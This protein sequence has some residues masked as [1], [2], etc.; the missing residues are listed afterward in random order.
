MWSEVWKTEHHRARAQWRRPVGPV[1]CTRKRGAWRAEVNGADETA[2]EHTAQPGKPAPLQDVKVVD[3]VGLSHEPAMPAK[4]SGQVSKAAEELD[5]CG[6]QSGSTSSWQTRWRSPAQDLV[7]VVGTE[8]AV[9]HL[10]HGEPLELFAE[11]SALRVAGHACVRSPATPL[12]HLDQRP[13]PAR[14]VVGRP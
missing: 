6:R 1:A 5:G 7:Q 3:G 4:C 8:L 10:W 14:E 9:P 13:A 11:P 12:L 2:H